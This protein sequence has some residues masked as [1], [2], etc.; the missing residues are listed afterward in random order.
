MTPLNFRQILKSEIASW[1]DNNRPRI[2]ALIRRLADGL[3]PLIEEEVK[4]GVQVHCGLVEPTERDE[5]A[6]LL[7][8][9]A[10]FISAHG[11]DKANKIDSW[12]RIMTLLRS[13][14]QEMQ[15][16]PRKHKEPP[17]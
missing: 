8:M 3:A 6:E 16:P 13:K 12:E 15:A 1:M 10:D 7:D 11:L 17:L 5:I 2:D 14:A 4:R 9:A